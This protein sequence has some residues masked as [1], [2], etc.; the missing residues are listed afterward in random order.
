MTHG[1]ARRALEVVNVKSS[2]LLRIGLV[3]LLGLAF[4]SSVVFTRLGIREI[5]P[6]SLA[7]LRLAVATVAFT[8]TLA[9]LHRRLPG[10]TRVRWDIAMVGITATGLPLMA[11]TFALL[12]FSSGMLSIMIALTPL[13]TAF[14]A[15]LWLADERL[16]WRRLAGLAAALI[17]V[18]FLL[19]TGTTGL[20]SAMTSSLDWRGPAL[21]LGGV[22]VIAASAVYTRRRLRGVDPLVVAGGQTAVGLL[23]VLPFALAFSS[24]DLSMITWRGWMAVL[25]T[26]LIGSFLAFFFYIIKQFGATTAALSNYVMPVTSAMLGALMLGEVI[27][28]PMIAG[29]GLIFSGVYLGSR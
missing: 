23:F 11:F 4:G 8:A 19:A 18:L 25:Y 28:L 24:L 27:T 7:G 5:P 9:L 29:A 14:T 26:G 1:A 17:G 20:T 16:T 6:L 3:L 21:S 13:I 15:H 22:L 12:F 10:E 2:N